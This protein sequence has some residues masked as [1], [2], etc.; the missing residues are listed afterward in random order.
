MTIVSK[1]LL[2]NGAAIT[3]DV[4]PEIVSGRTMLPIRFPA[5]ALGDDIKW[6]AET[7]EVTINF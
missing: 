7:Q 1:V 6:N 2:I 3:M 5:Q 4:A